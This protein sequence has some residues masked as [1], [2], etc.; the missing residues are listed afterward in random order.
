MDAKRQRI[1]YIP[2]IQNVIDMLQTSG[3][4]M[5]EKTLLESTYVRDKDTALSLLCEH[6]STS[7]IKGRVHYTPFARI[8]GR[9]DL[10]DLFRRH[11]P[12]G[13]RRSDLYGLYKFVEADVDELVFNCQLVVVEGSVFAN[14]PSKPPAAPDGFAK[15]WAASLSRLQ[16]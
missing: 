8:S 4:S 13:F 11:F 1:E 7:L 10:L 2:W 12:R 5:D 3:G 15:A 16:A 9:D 14:P 6:P